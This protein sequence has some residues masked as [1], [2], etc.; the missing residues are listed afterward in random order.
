MVRRPRLLVLG[1]IV[2][3]GASALFLVRGPAPADVP[4]RLTWVATAHQLG[5]VGYRDPVGVLSPDGRH[6]AYSEGPHVRV[7]P[8]GG[9]SPATLPAAEGQVRHLAWGVGQGGALV[10][11]DTRAASRWW[12]VDPVRGTRAPLFGQRVDLDGVSDDGSPAAVRVNDLRYLAPSPDGEWFGAIAAG[13]GGPEVWRIPAGGGRADV[14]RPGGRVSA[15]AWTASG[16]LACIQTTDGRPRITAPCGESPFRM[17]PDLDVVGPLAFSPDGATVYFASPGDRGMVDLWDADWRSGRAR[18]LTSFDRDTYAPVTAADGAVLFKTQ[19]YR[20]FVAEIDLTTSRQQPLATFQSETP[21]YDPTGRTVAVTFGTWRRVLDDVN[22]PDIAQEIGTVPSRP[23]AGAAAAPLDVIADS[24]SEDQAM[25]WSPNGRWIALHSHREMSDDVWL[26]PVDGSAP[27]RRITFLGRGAEVGWPRW[28][29]DGRLVLLDGARPNDGPSVM[30]V[31]GVDQETGDVTSPLREIAVTGLDGD[32]QHA[33]WLGGSDRVV[34]I[35]R[36]AAGRH[37]ILSVPVRGGMA[38]ILH[39][40]AS[41]HDFP[42]LAASPDGREV[43]FVQR[44]SDGFY[45]IFRL[46]VAAGAAPAQ[47][48]FDPSHKSQPAWSPDGE[49][50]AYTVWSYLAHFWTIGRP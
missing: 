6:L 29:P 45:Q 2:V 15:P 9:G 7:V 18:R 36:E 49:R 50:M 25:T 19:S 32:L 47:V 22:Y 4:P 38:R 10:A 43:A 40:F 30:F 12:L 46:A 20:T 31:I 3:V 16:E 39:R 14:R 34:A 37:V 28:S 24:I 17:T 42:G 44:A 23:A 13:A 21:S 5:V 41:D 27:D 26:R 1:A 8:I 48:T 11:E 35:G 33:E